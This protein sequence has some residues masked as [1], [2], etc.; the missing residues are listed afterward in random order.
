MRA[1]NNSSGPVQ[2]L[3]QISVHELKRR[4]DDFQILDVRSPSEWEK[5]HIPRA[6]HMF[7]PEVRSRLKEIDPDKPVA[8]YCDSGYRASIA[9][10]V[11]QQEGLEQVY[12]V[13]GSWQA[14][15]KAGYPV[16]NG[17]DGNA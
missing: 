13:P 12:N 8:T 15:K 4:L 17:K 2:E 10:S 1:W 3:P 11:L 6:R 14:W 5:G 16:A 7:V 9:A